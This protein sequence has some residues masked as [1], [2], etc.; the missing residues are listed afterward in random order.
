MNADGIRVP[1]LINTVSG[2]SFYRTDEG[3]LQF[4]SV[5]GTFKEVLRAPGVLLLAD[6]KRQSKPIAKN[7]SAS[8][9]DIGDGVVAVECKTNGN[10]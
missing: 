9:W 8:L 6:I 3:V 7:M 1:E 10:I 4:L 2:K 5:E